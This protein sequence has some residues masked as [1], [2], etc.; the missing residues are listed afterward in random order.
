MFFMVWVTSLRQS[1]RTGEYHPEFKGLMNSSFV[2]L[3]HVSFVNRVQI[4]CFIRVVNVF[5]FSHMLQTLLL[6]C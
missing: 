3:R 6:L 5:D 2:K 1:G 4:T